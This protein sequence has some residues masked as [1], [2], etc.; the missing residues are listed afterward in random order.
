MVSSTFPMSHL[1]SM[2]NG[3]FIHILNACLH[4]STVHTLNVEGT[5]EW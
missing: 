3:C 1:C 5:K 4:N 2:D